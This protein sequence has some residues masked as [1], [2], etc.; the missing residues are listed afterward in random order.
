M[1]AIDEIAKAKIHETTD[2]AEIN[3]HLVV[4]AVVDK[5][6]VENQEQH[7][8]VQQR[9]RYIIR[10][11][12]TKHESGNMHFKRTRAQEEEWLT[13]SAAYPT[14][15]TGCTFTTE[16]EVVQGGE[17]GPVNKITKFE[18]NE[19]KIE[20]LEIELRFKDEKS[21]KKDLQAQ[22]QK[23]DLQAQ[24]DKRDLQAQLDKRDL[25]A[26]IEQN[27]L[28]ANLERRCM[29]LQCKMDAMGRDA[30]KL[31]IEQMKSNQLAQRT[32]TQSLYTRITADDSTFYGKDGNVTAMILR[33][34]LFNKDDDD[35]I[36]E[37]CIA[38]SQ[39]KATDPTLCTLVRRPPRTGA[40]F[41]WAK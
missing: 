36:K 31:E 32:K 6:E 10:E 12:M 21:E 15:P 13:S 26:Q 24:L 34:S 9:V 23:Q 28:Q 39:I 40:T 37:I 1:A 4:A 22:L 11:E 5:V 2:S 33:A 38:I 14:V 18:V 8:G 30:L 29:E 16:T 41:I 35:R 17:G 19:R 3:E 25:Q 7:E 20:M 27:H